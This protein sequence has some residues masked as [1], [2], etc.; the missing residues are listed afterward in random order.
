MYELS[1]I[2]LHSVGPKGARYQDVIIDLRNVGPV[3]AR[4]VQQALF[5]ADA[6]AGALRRP[7]PA[8][9][10][11]LENGGGKT[12][13]MKLIFS[14]MLPGRRN[15]LGSSNTR[16]LED[17][18]LAA[19]LAQIALEWQ[20]T[21]TGERVVTGKASEW[22]GHTVSSDPN[23]FSEL[24][25]TFRPTASF[26]LDTL[27]LTVDGRLL[28]LAGF[29]D[30][31]SQASRAE[32][33]LQAAWEIN[34]REWVAKLEN[35]DLDPELFRYQRAMNAGEGEA[36]D[37]F[38]FKSDEAFVDF[39]LRAVT[40]E[41][42]PRGLAEILSGYASKLAQRG[43]LLAE[44]DFVAGALELISPLA[45][46]AQEA[47]VARELARGARLDAERLA[48]SL[49][50]RHN[51]DTAHLRTAEAQLGETTKLETAADQEVRRLGAIT[52]EL[53]RLVAKMRLAAARQAQY[54]LETDRDRLGGMVAAWQ[55]TDAAV[56]NHTAAAA[57]Q[58]IRELVDT[59]E[60][61]ARPALAARDRAARAL[62]R[63]LL[64]TADN[65]D[66]ERVAAEELATRL[67]QEAV[68]AD[69][70]GEAAIRRGEQGRTELTTARNLIDRAQ[71]SLQAA[72]DD[73]ILAASDH[74]FAAAGSARTEAERAKVAVTEGWR[75][76]PELTVA[77]KQAEAAHAALRSAEA[78]TAT[79]A[80][81]CGETLQAATARTDALAR[82]PRMAAVLGVDA[83][84]LEVDAEALCDRLDAAIHVAEQQRATLQTAQVEDERILHA[85]GG[86]GLLPPSQS[87]TQALAVLEEAGITA[88]AGWRYLAQLP[89]DQRDTTLH[90]YP[91]LVDGLV[92]NSPD[93][94]DDA[95][96]LLA[97]A[98][99]LPTTII[100][101]GATAALLHQHG[102]PAPAGLAFIVAPNP[103]LYDEQAAE[104]ERQRLTTTH[105]QRAER[106]VELDTHARA[107]LHLAERTRSWR[108]DF[109]T[110]EME[111]IAAASKAA[112]AEAQTAHLA[113]DEGQR[114]RDEAATAEDDLQTVLPALEQT[115]R[116]ARALADR[117][118]GLAEEAEQIP[119]WAEQERSAR[120][121]IAT[122]G[123]Q[124]A[125]ASD[126]ARSLRSQAS[127]HRD[128][129]GDH[130]RIR[131]ASRDEL[132][133]IPGAGSVDVSELVPAEALP[134][135]REIHRAAS[136]AYLR[137]EVGAD[138]LLELRRAEEI[139]SGTRA[140]WEAVAPDIRARAAALLATAEG[141]DAA[142][143]AA[144][145]V[146]TKQELS[147]IH[148]R[149]TQ[150][151]AEVGRLEN[152]YNNFIR[153]ERSLDP[154]GKPR[155]I[156]HGEELI[157]RASADH[158]EAR[159]TFDA[160]KDAREVLERR[161]G[162]TRQAVADFR[163][164]VESLA[165]VAPATVGAETVAFADTMEAAR[166]RRTAAR[167]ALKEAEGLLTETTLTVRTAADKLAQYAA[168]PRFEPVA[169]PVRRQIIAVNRETLPDHAG[170]WQTA[171]QPRLRT[172]DDDLAQINEHRNGIITRLHGMVDTAIR[173]LRLA[174][175]LSKLPANM[176]DWSG[177]EFLR[178]RF[179]E[180]DPAVLRE[181][182]GQV[183]DD[184][185]DATGSGGKQ[186]RDGL[187]LV[188]HGVRAAMP[189]GV[190][191]EMLKPDAVLRTERVRVS[192]ISDVF[193]GG[194]LLTAAIILYC[195]MAA[196]RA[197]ERG[198]AHQRHAG[199]LFLD[200]P[201][202]R[203]S[204]GYLLELQ[205]A[206]AEAL[207]VQ[208]IYTTGLF[209]TNALS[210]FP[211]VVRLRNDADLR[212]GLKY[213]SVDS[214][215]RKPLDALGDPDDTGRLAATRVYI[216]PRDES[217]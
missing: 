21:R 201:I 160:I 111:R 1:R 114:L 31:L 195:T 13:L 125:S 183:V 174:Q 16:V 215:V 32:P 147:A 90:H 129:A 122:S 175:R 11:F 208:L 35:L 203:A 83:V 14:V 184:A 204:A 148:G 20:H 85:L 68:E 47:A 43:D 192:S 75:R 81:R 27:P 55:A 10:L 110:G 5:D 136:A 18:V 98:R 190:T 172:L 113:A 161:I 121:L 134:E 209:D 48:A 150:A 78:E 118:A 140:A 79:L 146:R 3:V 28:T 9:V 56:A 84:D 151:A 127:G 171:L 67:E 105:K 155:D 142:A 102:V 23:R 210:A 216:R 152:E 87:V 169:S 157:T 108:R 116:H 131:D 71:A 120:E 33:R 41:E 4:P 70:A 182:L 194:Q 46:A 42:D 126:R 72:V 52:L 12:V 166:G 168:D 73:G 187:S 104:Q 144:A 112:A 139:E 214:E 60:E 196:L 34:H 186:Q 211:L 99:L 156:A 62:A 109:P 53:R 119:T 205:L 189:K 164:V 170:D 97:E 143:R 82:E 92:L 206:V 94:L 101:V 154:Y 173:T 19:D 64:N 7:S 191:V 22:R 58:S 37:A 100:A 137:V 36:A 176:G 128:R 15:V 217:A 69:Q 149:I 178:I 200:N 80:H 8:T 25:Y 197:N 193:S 132:G 117:L 159:R 124:H 179:T 2:R 49:M 40:N 24:W 63:A 145:I 135:L 89:A 107:D 74:I 54:D 66:L 103:A 198:H 50:A 30:R 45:A 77:R 162:D 88:W 65:A 212:A 51:G 185:A 57:A 76:L 181:R 207:G 153:Q 39:L 123:R 93:R 130:R 180:P 86:G 141:A 17:Y 61:Q 138:L 38:T 59:K 91:H 165:D 133:R 106:I 26:T 115:E 29:R 158:G 167:Q 6:T 163:A 188:L 202:G 199:V 44:R 177:Q 213:L 95:E 96:R